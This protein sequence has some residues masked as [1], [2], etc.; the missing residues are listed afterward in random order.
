MLN[1]I[2]DRLVA[3]AHRG[4]EYS[5]HACA[6][7]YAIHELGPIGHMLG[8]STILFYTSAGLLGYALIGLTTRI[9]HAVVVAASSRKAVQ[10]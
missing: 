4:F 1:T 2:K 9:A 8:S 7:G 10:Q 6:I 3:H 5:E